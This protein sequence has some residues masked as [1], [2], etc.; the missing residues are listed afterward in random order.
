MAGHDGVVP[1]TVEFSAN[2]VGRVRSCIGDDDPFGIDVGIEFTHELQ[3]RR[4]IAV[5]DIFW[6]AK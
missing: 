1:F 4:G 6:G 3:T 5:E 2:D